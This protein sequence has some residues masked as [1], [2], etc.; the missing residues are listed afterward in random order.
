MPVPAQPLLPFGFPGLG[1]IPRPFG[2]L[3]WP[4]RKYMQMS[5]CP[6]EGRPP[7]YRGWESG[8]A[9]GGW[10]GAPAQTPVLASVLSLRSHYHAFTWALLESSGAEDLRGGS[11]GPGR[12]EAGAARSDPLRS[13]PSAPPTP[14]PATQ[15]KRN[16]SP[17]GVQRARTKKTQ[18]RPALLRGL[19]AQDS[20]GRGKGGPLPSRWN[21]GNPR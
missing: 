5:C 19:Q 4:R 3:H 11:P 15:G 10:G 16:W 1:L 20:H 8:A 12:T 13:V 2:R 6:A 7:K 21:P 17:G 14:H 9:V 18:R